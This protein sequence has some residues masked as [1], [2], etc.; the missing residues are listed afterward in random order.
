MS[1]IR[2]CKYCNAKISIREMPD[3]QWVAFE[4]QTDTAHE[5][6]DNIS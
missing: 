3:G 1:Y 5:C 2:K 6:Y 4:Y